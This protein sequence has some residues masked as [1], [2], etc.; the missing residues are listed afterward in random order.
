MDA[1]DEQDAAAPPTPTDTESEPTLI[2]AAGLGVDGEHGPLFSDIDLE[3]T[4]GRA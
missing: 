4:A 2:T 3:L 1:R